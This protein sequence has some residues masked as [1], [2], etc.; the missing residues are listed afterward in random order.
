MTCDEVTTDAHVAAVLDAFGVAVANAA[1]ADI[2]TRTSE[3]LT[4]PA[5]TKYR[6]E[7][8]MMRYLRSLADKDLALDRSMIPLGSCT[9]KLNAAA[10]MESITWPEFAR[11]H[12]VRAGI[13]QPGSAQ[14]DRRPGDLAGPDD[15][16]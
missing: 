3:F 16:L 12:P 6:T 10:E 5:F 8:S 13:R 2:A 4:H 9:M 7:T 14:A 11:Q 15:R 1:S